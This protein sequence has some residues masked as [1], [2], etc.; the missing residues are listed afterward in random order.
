MVFPLKYNFFKYI[1]LAK[2]LS[3]IPERLLLGSNIQLPKLRL[4]TQLAGV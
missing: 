3:I 2:E 1:R 4:V